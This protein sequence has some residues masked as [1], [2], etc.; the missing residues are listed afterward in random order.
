MKKPCIGLTTYP[1]GENH[2]WHTPQLYIDAV[3][4]AGGVPVLLPSTFNITGSEGTAEMAQAWLE[5]VDGLVFIG[6]GD[7]NPNYYTNDTHETVY[8]LSLERDSSEM[9]LM[10]AV[11]ANPKPTLAICRGLQLLNTVLGGTLHLHL[12][13]VVGEVILHRNPPREAVGHDIAILPDSHLATLLGTTANTAS[14]HHQAIDKLGQGLRVVATAPDGVIEAVELAG[15]NQL[16][17]VQWHPE[18]T[19]EKDRDQQGLFEW[20]VNTASQARG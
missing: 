10:K 6:G 16:V 3:V 7:V 15:N 18:M 17:A 2:G 14:W 5:K 1:A 9:A 8:N 19:A 4:R 20:L 11:L 12:P 13:D